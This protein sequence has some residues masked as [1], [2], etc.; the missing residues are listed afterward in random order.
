MSRT[1]RPRVAALERVITLVAYALSTLLL[2]ALGLFGVASALLEAFVGGWG[3][4]A[5]LLGSGVL[6]LGGAYGCAMVVLEVLLLPP[7]IRANRR[8][9]PRSGGIAARDAPESPL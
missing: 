3:R 1:P 4:G 9:S 6:L 7:R 2:A 5:L 8:E